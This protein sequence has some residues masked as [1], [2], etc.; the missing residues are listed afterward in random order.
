MEIY[1]DLT[2]TANYTSEFLGYS[3]YDAANLNPEV[4][5]IHVNVVH[6]DAENGLIPI[7]DLEAIIK[8]IK[9][10]GASHIEIG[11]HEDHQE[12]EL[13]GFTIT[14]SLT[15]VAETSWKQDEFEHYKKEQLKYLKA[16]LERLEEL[17]FESFSNPSNSDDDLPF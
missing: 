16:E 8:E 17:T 2:K 6:S 9:E 12:Y 4:D 1:L 13:N 15:E 11:F 14:Q 10:T 3:I 5:N 7:E